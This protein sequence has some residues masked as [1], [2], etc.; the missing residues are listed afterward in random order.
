MIVEIGLFR[1]D[2]GRVDTFA[3]VADDIRGA[4]TSGIPGV[5]FFRMEPAIEDQGRW[6]VLA[7]WDSLAD[8]ERFVAS[9]EGVRQ[10]RLLG[11]FMVGDP[12]VFHLGVDGD[13]A[14]LP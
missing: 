9:A 13:G 8:H 10:Q 11:A 12:D 7:G 14:L 1:I 2:P 5:R 6:A 3:A 4:F